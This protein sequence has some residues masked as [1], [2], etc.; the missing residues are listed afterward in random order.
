ME[1]IR[2]CK[3]HGRVLY[4]KDSTGHWRCTKCCSE[5]VQKRRV[6]IKE[7]AAQ[8]KGGKCQICGYS[9]YIGA[10][11]FHHLNPNEKDFGISA[12]G[13]T[14]NLNSVKAELDKCICVCSNCHREI[15]AG[16]VQI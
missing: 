15:H 13:Y 12:R 16:L 5:A 3:K 8:Y 14:R 7:L 6:K 4:R 11:E 9:R 10:L 1:E 2:E